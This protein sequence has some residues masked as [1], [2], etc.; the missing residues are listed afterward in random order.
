MP[1][2]PIRQRRTSIV[3]IA[4]PKRVATLAFARLLVA[5]ACSGGGG[6][7]ERHRPR[8]PSAARPAPTVAPAASGGVTG[9]IVVSGS[10]TVQPISE[11]RQRGLQGRS[12]PAS[13][14]PSKARV[15]VTAS[16]SSAPGRR[17]S[18]TRRARSRPTRP[19]TA[20]ARRTGRLRRAQDRHRRHLGH[21]VAE[22]QRGQLPELSRTLYAL[23]GPESTGFAKWSDA[24]A[25][26]TAPR[27][28]HGVPGRALTITGPARSPARSIRFVEIVLDG[29]AKDRDQSDPEDVAHD[30]APGLHG[31]RERQRDHRG[32]R[33]QRRIAGLG[34]LRL[35]RG[36]PGQG[37][38][39]P[40]RPRTRTAPAS[41]RPPRRSP[42]ATTRSRAASTSTSTRPRRPRTP[43]SR[44]GSTTTSRM[45][46]STRSSRRSP[47]VPLKPETLKQT[48]DAWAAAKP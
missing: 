29:V 13:T 18:P 24:A 17:T 14:T 16:R 43:R 6:A 47:Y 37:Q 46:P 28:E 36:E 12:T 2:G 39:D 15:P 32:R 34:R 7:S 4:S 1:R 3:G 25:L 22:E 33:R 31:E 21:D 45:A 23:V 10:S 35:L 41:S 27:L 48:Q 19:R 40:G 11:G 42:R 20:C 26:A 44:P 9:S 8:A 38:G 5:G 30:H